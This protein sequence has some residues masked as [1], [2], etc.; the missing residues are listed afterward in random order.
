[1]DRD[2]LREIADSR[3]SS[4][5]AESQLVASL[6]GGTRQAPLVEFFRDPG[7]IC[8]IKRASPSRGTIIEGAD[9]GDILET[10]I[11]AG[12]HR[13]SV[14]TENRHF[15][16]SCSDLFRLKNLHPELAFLRKDFL[17]TKEDIR[18]SY[19][20]GA[21]A[22]LLIGE[23]LEIPLLE[24]LTR[25]AHKLGLQVLTEVHTLQLARALLSSAP[26]TVSLPDALGLNSRDLR[27]FTVNTKIPFAA[28]GRY[29]RH[30]R[31]VFESGIHETVTVHQA[32]NAG[33]HGVLIGEACMRSGKKGVASFIE[34]FR[35]GASAPPCLF[36]RLMGRYALK[37]LVKVCG[38][39]R[40]KDAELAAEL[41]ADMVGFILAP[42]SRR[43][44]IEA[45]E[46]FSDIEVLKCAVVQ[47]PDDTLLDQLTEKIALGHIHGIQFH[48][49]ESPAA[50][51]RFAGNACKAVMIQGEHAPADE[52]FGPFTLFDLPKNGSGRSLA[53]LP[54]R[55]ELRGAFL[56]GGINRDTLADILER[57]DPLLIDI[58]SGIESSP[59]IK[60]HGKMRDIFTILER[61]YG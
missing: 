29:G 19:L 13:F 57:Y 55:K 33:F 41:G 40:R 39:T 23:L 9:I 50:V 58:S 8:E 43:V 26:D 56:A 44:T 2:I 47:D 38:I 54:F 15:S 5:S 18:E 48:G 61:I 37:P 12:A 52:G 32:A 30:I 27:D 36:T 51:S 24:S 42:S 10:Y 17:L 35:K 1:M 34:A 49:N 45:L 6:T 22:V 46:E 3:I 59:G 16:G 14:L 7:L 25:E 31:M 21:D 11:E 53:D 20:I 28:V 4:R 60:D